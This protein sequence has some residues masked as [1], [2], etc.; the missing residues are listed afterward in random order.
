MKR[1]DLMRPRINRFEPPIAPPHDPGHLALHR[2]RRNALCFSHDQLDAPNV[3]R[4]LHEKVRVNLADCNNEYAVSGLGE[5]LSEHRSQ[6]R[7]QGFGNVHLVAR[8]LIAIL[9]KPRVFTHGRW[10][11][12]VT[13]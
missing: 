10:M 1:P 8:L 4:Q 9:L 7:S 2:A 13:R 6:D 3:I 11:F 5:I 12:V